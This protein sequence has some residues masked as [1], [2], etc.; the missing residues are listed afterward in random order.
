MA[1]PLVSVLIP[2]FNGENFIKEAVMSVLDQTYRPIEILVIDDGSED[3][4]LKVLSS[5]TIVFVFF[6]RKMAGLQVH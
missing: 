2:V 4:T 5:L 6:I 1:S 3:N